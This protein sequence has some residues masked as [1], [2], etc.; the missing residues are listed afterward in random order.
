MEPGGTRSEPPLHVDGTHFVCWLT[1][2]SAP[3]TCGQ[4]QRA[5]Q[6]I[7]WET[8]KKSGSSGHDSDESDRSNLR[9]TS[10]GVSKKK[11]KKIV[12]SYFYPY[13][14]AYM[15]VRIPIAIV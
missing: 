13:E 5:G 10:H 2:V 9:E 15:A 4:R 6:T 8:Q 11:V 14:S 3:T 7:S 1:H 12:S